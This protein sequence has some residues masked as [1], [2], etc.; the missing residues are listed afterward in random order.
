MIKINC[1]G[2]FTPNRKHELDSVISQESQSVFAGCHEVG[3]HSGSAGGRLPRLISLLARCVG[4]AALLW[5]AGSVSPCQTKPF[6][7]H[8]GGISKH[9]PAGAM[10]GRAGSG[11]ARALL[12]AVAEPWMCC[13]RVRGAWV[14]A[15]GALGHSP[16]CWDIPPRQNACEL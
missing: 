10:V 5:A 3:R 11:N 15:R 7:G 6:P 9:L 16:A 8:R 1:H 14:G 13:R 2:T 12:L 4:A